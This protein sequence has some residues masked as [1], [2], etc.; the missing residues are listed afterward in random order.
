MDGR[1]VV[2]DAE[3]TVVE[4]GPRAVIARGIGDEQRIVRDGQPSRV[5]DPEG[6]MARIVDVE[7]GEEAGDAEIQAVGRL[8][9]DVD[10]VEDAPGQ[11]LVGAVQYVVDAEFVEQGAFRGSV[12]AAAMAGMS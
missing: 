2:A 1:Q 8:V 3:G 9:V 10:V 6:R 11:A 5:A 4:D 12:T 7:C